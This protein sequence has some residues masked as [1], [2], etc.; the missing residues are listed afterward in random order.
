MIQL[1]IL[2]TTMENEIRLHKLGIEKVKIFN[3]EF[4]RVYDYYK[5][6]AEDSGYHGELKF[7]KE[8]GKVIIYSIIELSDDNIDLSI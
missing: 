3:K 6:K 4:D 8:R 2:L 1:I 5:Q 7:I